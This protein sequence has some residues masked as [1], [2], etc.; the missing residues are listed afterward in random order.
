MAKALVTDELWETIE[1]LLPEEPPKPKGGRPRVPDRATLTSI[2]F[3]L[4]TGIPWEMLPQ[5]MGRGSGMTCW[6]RLE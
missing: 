6:R 4:K 1:P 2:L 5:E 3:V